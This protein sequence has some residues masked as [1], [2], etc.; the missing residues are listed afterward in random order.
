MECDGY[1]KYEEAEDFRDNEKTLNKNG[2]QS[3]ILHFTSAKIV[4]GYPCV[5]P[6]FL[7]NN[8]GPAIWN[9]F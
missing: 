7:F 4:N 8:H 5:I 9:Y 1:V 6:Y 2:R 3:A